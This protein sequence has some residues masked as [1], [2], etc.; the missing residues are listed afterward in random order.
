MKRAVAIKRWSRRAATAAF[1]CLAAGALAEPLTLS[2]PLECEPGRSCFVQTYVAHEEQAK[3][4]DYRCGARTYS[5]HDGTD[6]R[7]AD[8]P[9]MRRGVNVLATAAG[10]VV[11]M[12]DGV[13]DGDV[14]E[15]QRER[16]RGVECGNGVV[17]AHGDGWET[18]YCHM[19]NGSLRVGAGERVEAGAVLGKLGLSGMT[20][21]PHLHFT[22]RQ[23]GRVVD[24][25]AFG[26]A[27]GS[28]GGGAFLW[29]PDLREALAYRER[30]LLNFG[31]ASAPVGMQD[32][33]AGVEPPGHEPGA[34]VAYVRLIG[35]QKGDRLRLVLRGPD[36]GI[37]A[38][39][40]PDPL[41]SDKAQQMLFVGARRP[42]QGGPRGRYS[43]E[44][45]VRH[46]GRIV[47]EQT[48]S[49]TF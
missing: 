31:F 27:E 36:D 7:V 9:A 46:E 3:P 42:P 48:F 21:F 10:T 24:P 14:L 26:A 44:I 16:V 35:L 45:A 18:Q 40:E 41:T 28:C 12:R 8:I 37:V 49:R 15:G 23:A 38:D 34:L 5:R 17:I 6:F 32:I 47:L 19:A 39:H 20:E 4:R 25:F 33:E 2:L 13:S 30:E 1:C 11:R 22:V 29:R 43:A